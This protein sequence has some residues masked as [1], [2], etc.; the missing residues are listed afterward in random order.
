MVRGGRIGIAGVSMHG[1]KGRDER[2]LDEIEMLR[3]SGE[4]FGDDE[5]EMSS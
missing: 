3:L 5:L 2:R 4:V 1:V